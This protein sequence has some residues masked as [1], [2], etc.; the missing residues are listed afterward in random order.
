MA[1]CACFQSPLNEN[2]APPNLISANARQ[3]SA[4]SCAEDRGSWQGSLDGRAASWVILSQVMTDT[5]EDGYGLASLAISETITN[6]VP[7]DPNAVFVWRPDTIIVAAVR[8]SGGKV[9]ASVV[10][11]EGLE[12]RPLIFDLIGIDKSGGVGFIGSCGVE[13][14]AQLARF[15]TAHGD[16]TGE[17]L[18]REVIAN[19]DGTIAKALRGG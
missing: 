2:D 18:L 13:R 11:D 16:T 1:A 3:W 17:D 6:D 12:I 5:T 14:T 15:A 9:L 10:D 7:F 4:G 8:E 19:P